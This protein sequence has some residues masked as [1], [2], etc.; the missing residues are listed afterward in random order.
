M[1]IVMTK[2]IFYGWFVALA[3][4]AALAANAAVSGL[5]FS[6][7]AQTLAPNDFSEKITVTTGEAPGTT[8]DLTLSSSSATGEFSSSNTNWQ[9]TS[10]LTWNSNWANRSFYYRDS[11]VG[12][13]TLTA[14]LT[15]RDGGPSWSANQSITI[16]ATGSGSDDEQS[17][18]D[19]DPDT[20]THNDDGAGSNVSSS[21][22]NRGLSS[23][24]SP[25]VLS[26][27][28]EAD[29]LKVSAGRERLASIGAPIVFRARA[30]GASATPRFNWSFGDG[31]AARGEAATHAYL[32]PGDYEVVLNAHA[33]EEEATSRTRVRVL[34]PDLTFVPV[35]ADASLGWWLELKNQSDWEINLGGWR[36]GQ[37]VFPADTIIRAGAGLPLSPEKFGFDRRWGVSLY[38]PDGRPALTYGAVVA[39]APG[40]GSRVMLEQALERLRS[41]INL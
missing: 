19:S 29:G 9:A 30:T 21:S 8:G 35:D 31:E 32:L 16:G 22:T 15:V 20:D 33:A 5:S 40:I 7:E 24:Q 23:H 4:F 36:L 38:Y 34:K 10:Q 1:N 41:Q 14:T 13:H 27:W 37:F 2:K 17:D 26:A 12:T 18:D 39:A 28:R 11:T 3:L 6:S 25:A